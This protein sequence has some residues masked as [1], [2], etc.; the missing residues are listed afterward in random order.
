MQMLCPVIL[1]SEIFLPLTSANIN[2][3]PIYQ[4]SSRASLSL[5][6]DAGGWLWN[7]TNE[8]RLASPQTLIWIWCLFSS[9]GPS[10][11]CRGSEHL[12]H[13]HHRLLHPHQAGQLPAAPDVRWGRGGGPQQPVRPQQGPGE[14]EQR[15]GLL[16]A[17]QHQV[18]KLWIL[19]IQ[20]EGSVRNGW[21]LFTK[22]YFSSLC[23]RLLLW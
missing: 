17:R 14:K 13:L 21:K 18:K 4:I 19:E 15:F 23:L 5:Q 10:S 8:T 9:A 11:Y 1:L 20:S 12:L 7:H 6:P 3:P 2:N 16:P 22:W